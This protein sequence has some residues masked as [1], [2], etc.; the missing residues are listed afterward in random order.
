MLMAF[1]FDPA[2]GTGVCTC[3]YGVRWPLV[4]WLFKYWWWHA[5]FWKSLTLTAWEGSFANWG[6]SLFLPIS[7]LYVWRSASPAQPHYTV[8]S[9][10]WLS[11]F[12]SA[13]LPPPFSWCTGI[14]LSYVSSVSIWW[15]NKQMNEWEVNFKWKQFGWI[16]HNN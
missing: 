15:M 7:G 1:E 14:C 2:P 11:L 3:S 6:Q 9:Y 10:L 12:F 4:I 13:Y 5:A 8:K 16:S